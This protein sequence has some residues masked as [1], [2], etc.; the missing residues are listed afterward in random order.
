MAISESLKK[1]IREQFFEHPVIK[2]NRFTAWF[3][4]GA[5]DEDD[6][7]ELIRQFSVF[8]NHFL[9][10]QVK[11]LVNAGTIEGEI[12][13]RNILVNECGVAL[14]A[15]SGSPEGRAF[16]TTN[17][18]LN[19]LRD[20]GAAL[21]MPRQDLGRWQLGSDATHRFLRG[22]DRTYG[23]P[24]PWIGAGAS[25]AIETWAAFGI[26]EGAELETRNFW[27]QLITGL[28]IFN[29]RRQA[30]GLKPLPLGFFKFHF[31]TE[32]G[33]GANVWHELE[34]SAADPRFDAKKFLKGGRQA[35]ES[36]NEFWLGL[37]KSRRSPIFSGV[38]ISQWAF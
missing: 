6:V 11:R 24:D 10:L 3:A 25:F 1:E 7:A 13:A 9:V 31:A 29:D 26:G 12:C 14:D 36:I 22:L 4:R 2:D 5:A 35:L 18:H 30:A 16:S 33:H 8:S 20:C 17:A 15:N 27:R 19:W 23:S 38:N 21:G 32:S 28:E 37:E 34:Q